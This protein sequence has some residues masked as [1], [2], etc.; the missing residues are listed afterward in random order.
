MTKRHRQYPAFSACGLNCGLCPHYHVYGFMDCPGCA[1]EGSNHCEA[2]KI[3][4]CCLNKGLEFCFL[5]TEF[6]CAKYDGV[7]AF[8]SFIT[9]KNQRKN[10][11]KAQKVGLDAYLDEQD[12]K[13]VF[14]RKLICRDSDERQIDLLCVAVNLLELQDVRTVMEQVEEGDGADAGQLFQEMADRRQVP[15]KLRRN[16]V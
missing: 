7:D 5:C 12:E 14:L 2:C 10:L 9:H 3:L 16:E 1:G 6:P 11:E 4:A 8:D 15:L 13:I